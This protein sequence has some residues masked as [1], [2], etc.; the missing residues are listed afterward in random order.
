[1]AT[2]KISLK[3]DI[4]WNFVMSITLVSTKMVVTKKRSF[5]VTKVKMENMHGIKYDATKKS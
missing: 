1:M 5:V 3:E 4:Y 2:K